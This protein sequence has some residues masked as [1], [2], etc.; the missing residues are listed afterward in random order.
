MLIILTET[1]IIV[2]FT[3]AESKNCLTKKNNGSH[4]FASSLMAN[5]KG[6]WCELD[7]ITLRNLASLAYVRGLAVTLSVLD[8]SIVL[9]VARWHHRC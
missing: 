3:K 5:N 4:N 1:L 2:S 8:L 7:M 9:S 6:K